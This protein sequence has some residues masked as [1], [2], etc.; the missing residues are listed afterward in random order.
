[1]RSSLL[2]ATATLLALAGDARALRIA[3]PCTCPTEINLPSPGATTL[4]KNAKRWHIGAFGGVH[5][6]TVVP[7]ADVLGVRRTEPA[8]NEWPDIELTEADH[9]PPAAPDDVTVSISLVDD[10]GPYHSL[11]LLAVGGRFDLDA[12]LLRIDMRDPDGVVSFI[13][14]P[15]AARLCVPGAQLLGKEFSVDV[16]TIDLAG[17]ESVPVA[18]HVSTS[19]VPQATAESCS[20]EQREYR[21]AYGPC[22]P[23]FLGPVL[24]YIIGLVAWILVLAVRGGGARS[25]PGER[26]TILAAEEVLRRLVR[27]ERIWAAMLLVAIL[28]LYY[29]GEELFAGLLGPVGI[30]ALCRLFVYRWARSLLDQPDATVVR[31]GRWLCVTAGRDFRLIRASKRD[32]AA[33]QR[34]SIPRSVAR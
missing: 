1:M 5:T 32:L 34:A 22:V 25:T 15:R 23:L 6:R 18:A 30:V 17:N 29:S 19:L 31:H 7:T 20:S 10:V 12:A 33:G 2:I 4:P 13:T 3:R 21:E 14:T 27:W 28:G 9:V 11:N 16:R 24:V 26:I 8:A